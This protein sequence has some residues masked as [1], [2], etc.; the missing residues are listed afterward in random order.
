MFEEW[1]RDGAFPLLYSREKVETATE[2]RILLK[3]SPEAH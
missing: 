3:H 1:A 2:Q